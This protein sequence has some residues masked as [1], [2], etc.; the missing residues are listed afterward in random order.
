MLPCAVPSWVVPQS[1]AQW[2]SMDSSPQL[3]HCVP[4]SS[5]PTRC[6]ILSPAMRL[7]KLA[8]HMAIFGAILIVVLIGPILDTCTLFLLQSNITAAGAAAQ[9]AAGL[10][11]NISQAIATFLVIR[12]LGEPLLEKLDRV[13]VQYGMMEDDD[14]I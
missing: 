4:T 13:K 9:Y 1:A 11:V 12:F 6:S 3:L 2:A 8:M 7:T 10:P 14:G 5:V